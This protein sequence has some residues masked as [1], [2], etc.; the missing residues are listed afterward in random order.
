[1]VTSVLNCR[2][3]VILVVGLAFVNA[4]SARSEHKSSTAPSQSLADYLARLPQVQRSQPTLTIGSLWNPTS[5]IAAMNVDNR[6]HAVGDV[7]TLEIAESLTAESKGSVDTQRSFSA[8]SGVTAVGGRVRTTGIQELFSPRSQS[9]LRGR[10]ATAA[11][12]TLQTR[13]AAQVAA[14]LPGGALVI[15]ARRV[16]AMNNQRQSILLRGIVR[17]A[18]IAG[19]NTVLSTSVSNLEIEVD[20]KGVISDAT[21]PVNWLIRTLLRLVNF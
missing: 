20:G 15:E 8:S 13:L 9:Q 10:G 11:T 18:D 7:L 5:Q 2:P 19:D 3:I 17:P 6:A 1:M 12:S 14:V 4:A 21:R 16:I